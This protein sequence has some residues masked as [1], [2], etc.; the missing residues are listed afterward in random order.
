MALSTELI[1]QFAKIA[2]NKN[3]SRIDE[4]TLYGEV[5]EYEDR[6][7]V[8]FDGSGEITPVTTIAEKDEDGNITNFR[9]G[10]A[11]VKTGDRVSVSLKNHSATIT[12]NLSD[13][14]MGRAEVII[15]DDSIIAKVGEQVQVKIDELGVRIDGVTTFANDLS[16]GLANGTTVIDGSC[17]KTGTID[18]QR[19]SLSGMI[20]YQYSVDGESDW[21][22]KQ[23]DADE[24]RRET[25]DGGKTWGTPYK[26]VGTDGADGADGSDANV[27][28]Y[29]RSTYIDASRVSSFHLQGNKIEAVIPQVEQA[30]DDVGF[31]ITSSFGD[32]TYQYLRIFAYEGD[33][34]D[35]VF[36]SP[37][38]GYATWNFPM[39]TL[40]GTMQ[41]NGNV[42]FHGDVSGVTATFA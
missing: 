13:P 24:Y 36:E 10:A 35:T 33:T 38:G 31:I 14:P 17:I 28:A 42:Y 32:T 3:T 30:R 6:I 37:C 20:Y 7:C 41:F 9:Y 21:H 4:V 15:N 34:P 25:F 2:S 19:I 27:P 11:S 29:I 1:S 5:L 22:E 26:F 23:T 12:G 39:T 16:N 8:K 40:H 18:A